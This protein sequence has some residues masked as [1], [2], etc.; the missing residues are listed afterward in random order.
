MPISIDV[1]AQGFQDFL[2]DWERLTGLGYE[3]A[4][5]AWINDI[6]FRGRDDIVR[7]GKRDL[8]DVRPQTLTSGRGRGRTVQYRN[9]DR[10]RKRG[11]IFVQDRKI[12]GTRGGAK[13]YSPAQVLIDSIPTRGRSENI[14]SGYGRTNLW[15][16]KN[17]FSDR[18]VTAALKKA[19]RW[20][21]SKEK[22]KTRKTTF[23]RKGKKPKGRISFVIENAQGNQGLV[24]LRVKL[25]FESKDN[26]RLPFIG[27]PQVM[28]YMPRKASWR[29]RIGR[30]GGRFKWFLYARRISEDNKVVRNGLD[31]ILRQTRK[32]LRRNYGKRF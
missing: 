13:R 1:N 14:G 26:R 15:I 24:L 11:E 27:D 20:Y 8:N 19:L 5:Q 10:N 2:R 30:Y 16:P 9:Y 18:Q 23:K 22:K 12:W 32:Q 29:R 7:W 28:A 31:I 17:G 4:L 21:K 25:P 3:R 6:G